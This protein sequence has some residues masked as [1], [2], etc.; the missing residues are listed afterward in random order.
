M[1]AGI[2]D[3][4]TTGI[5]NIT[6]G[7]LGIALGLYRGWALAL[8]VLAFVPL[9]AISIAAVMPALAQGQHTESAG[10]ARAGELATEAISSIRT[11][12]SNCGEEAEIARYSSQLK[13]VERAG[14]KKAFA[15]GTG[16]GGMWFF[17]MAAYAVGLWFGAT[18]VLSS[19]QNNPICRTNPI[20]DGC[21]S[22][23]T[24][25]NTFFAIIIGAMS[26]AQIGQPIAAVTASMISA[27]RIFAVVD[28]TPEI[29][30]LAV[31]GRRIEAPQGRIAFEGV[32]FAYPSRP[33][34]PV[35]HDFS[36]VV[37][38]GQ[39]VALVGHSGSVYVLLFV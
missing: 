28:R 2:G 38:P 12:S 22:G 20:A 5:Q 18:Q 11:V 10:Y 19:R 31:T 6:T 36:L 16:F 3:K 7:I 15:M 26:V 13:A 25:I 29:D 30:N 24:V 23:G 17:M 34:Q 35:L 39:T 9:M 14:V 21:F 32:S 1:L 37:E 27:A 33:D 8:V 4:M